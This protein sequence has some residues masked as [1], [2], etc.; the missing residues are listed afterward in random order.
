MAPS[1]AGASDLLTGGALQ[2]MEAA[3]LGLPFEVW[4]TYM[5][6]NRNYS[7]M[8]ALKQVYSEGGVKG[9]YGG[10]Q[11]K[12]V[13]SFLKGGILLFAK[14]LSM[15]TMDNLGASPVTSGLV[16]GFLGGVAQVSVMGP[17]TFLVTA[18]VTGDKSVTALDRVKST[19]KTQGI[20]GFYRGGTA[21]IM[22]QGSNWASRQG[23]TDVVRE[24]IRSTHGK[25]ESK[26]LSLMEE[27]FSGL[28]GGCLSTWNQPFEVLRIQAQAAGARGEAAQGVISTASMIVKQH[29]V[30]GLFQGVIPRMGLCVW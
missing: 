18:A 6:A 29:G 3:T 24:M 17:C 13:E 19:F 27:A 2:C 10:F 5:G 14:E 7:T 16:G 21:L 8:A 1:K 12:M 4:K 28:V 11:P 15:N 20:G 26:K 9:F 25:N 23:L 30:L 22:R